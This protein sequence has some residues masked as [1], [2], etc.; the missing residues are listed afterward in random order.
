MIR[1]DNRI[2]VLLW[3]SSLFEL[4]N[5]LR[6]FW[7]HGKTTLRKIFGGADAV[8]K[9][10]ALR[11]WFDWSMGQSGP[12]RITSHRI[13]T[14]FQNMDKRV[15]AVLQNVLQWIVCHFLTAYHTKVY[16]ISR[17]TWDISQLFEVISWYFCIIS[18]LFKRYGWALT[19]IWISWNSEKRKYRKN[20]EENFEFL[21]R[22]FSKN[23]SYII[24]ILVSWDAQKCMVC[25]EKSHNYW[26][27]GG[28]S[29]RF[30]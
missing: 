24:R 13:I 8:K 22:G 14:Y 19:L 17:C 16:F 5:I 23:E 18:F 28:R 25:W 15:A 21:N 6:L 2:D 11:S 10:A 12:A 30:P 27:N 26:D 4:S 7:F 9:A 1:S 29:Y 3:R 20:E